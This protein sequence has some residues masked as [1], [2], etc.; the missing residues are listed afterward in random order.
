MTVRGRNENLLTN[1]S[2][3]HFVMLCLCFSLSDD[4]LRPVSDEKIS[5]CFYQR[6]LIAHLLQDNHGHILMIC[7]QRAKLR[8][9]L[10][11][12]KEALDMS[13]RSE[14]F[15]TAAEIKGKISQAEE[16][17]EK[18]KTLNRTPKQTACVENVS[19]HSYLLIDK[20]YNILFCNH[21]IIN[22]TIKFTHS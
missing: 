14:D 15:A 10:N 16:R 18:T 5:K 3:T 9:E 6:S 1:S 8:V 20:L 21:N 22:E 12:L 2:S 11:E 7:S 19:K 4:L 13:V 17:I